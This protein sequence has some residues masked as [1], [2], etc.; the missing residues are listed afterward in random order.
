MGGMSL[1]LSPSDNPLGAPAL[2]AAIKSVDGKLGLLL[3]RINGA[4]FAGAKRLAFD[5]AAERE[6][7]FT[8]SIET[9]KPGA[10][11]GQGPR[12]NFLIYPPAE[13]KVFRVNVSLADFEHDANSPADPA[14][15]LEAARIKSIAI[16]DITALTGGSAADNKIWIG[17]MDLLK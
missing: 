17:R 6:G 16:G 8:I 13:S 9:R 4:D 2:A 15:T 11:G 3:R 10:A 1:S 12:Y 5:I 7:T 14:G